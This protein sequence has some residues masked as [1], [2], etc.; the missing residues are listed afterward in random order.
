MQWNTIS[1]KYDNSASNRSLYF[2]LN[3]MH[4]S[5]NEYLESICSLLSLLTVLISLVVKL[6]TLQ[7]GLN[8]IPFDF[9]T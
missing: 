9:E 7:W 3:L 1:I 2:S 6:F 8:V 5:L 4:N